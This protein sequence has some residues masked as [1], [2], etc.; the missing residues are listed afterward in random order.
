MRPLNQL[1]SVFR[2]CDR[3]SPFNF[4]VF[5]QISGAISMN[6]LQAA[7]SNQLTRYPRLTYSIDDEQAPAGA[8]VPTVRQPKVEMVGGPGLQAHLNQCLNSP[9]EC[10]DEPLMRIRW[11]KADGEQYLMLCLNHVVA[12]GRSG[13]RLFESLVSDLAAIQDGRP[14]TPLSDGEE[15]FCDSIKGPVGR[16]APMGG[17]QFKS[18]QVQDRR[19]V[20]MPILFDVATTQKLVEKTRRFGVSMSGLIAACHGMSVMDASGG[21]GSVS[22]HR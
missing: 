14:C 22:S 7:C 21:P 10:P 16:I 5:A 20:V 6:A 19:T 11:Y 12:D 9:F 15:P 1:E 18:A 13:L 3:A 8:W 2:V 4:V 17:R